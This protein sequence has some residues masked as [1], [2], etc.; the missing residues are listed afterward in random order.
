MMVQQEMHSKRLFVFSN[1]MNTVII[2]QNVANVKEQQALR[3]KDVAA[4]TESEKEN[5]E[6]VKDVDYENSDESIKR[7]VAETLVIKKSLMMPKKPKED[8]WLCNNIFYTSCTIKEKICNVIIDGGN[9]KNVISQDAVEKLQLK[10][11][12]HPSPYKLSWFKKGN[13]IT[14]RRRCLVSFSIGEV[15]F[16]NV[17]C[18]AVPKMDAYHI[19]F[20]RPWQYDK[21]T[22]HDEYRNT[23]TFQKVKMKIVLKPA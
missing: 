19:L 7:D 16:D 10:T 15:Y 22:L 6:E 23:Y 13:E 4:E 20:G 12:K 5:F 2:P 1:A 9:C 21:Q 17:I 18:D 3:G 11:K 14:I 8:S